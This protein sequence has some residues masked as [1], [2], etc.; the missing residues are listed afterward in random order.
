MKKN[1]SVNIPLA[2]KIFRDIWTDSKKTIN[3]FQKQQKVKLLAEIT[4]KDTKLQKHPF[5][6]SYL[7]EG[8]SVSITSRL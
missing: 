3:I 5:I 2:F 7:I 4:Q 6:S 8:L 1:K